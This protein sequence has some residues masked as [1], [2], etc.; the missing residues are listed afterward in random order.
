MSDWYAQY[1]NG[2][3]TRV[4]P[5]WEAELEAARP[6]VSGDLE[7]GLEFSD[8]DP[9]QLH[10]RRRFRVAPI[11]DYQAENWRR[12]RRLGPPEGDQ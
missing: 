10:N 11:T 1:V 12:D 7:H 8:Q 4:L 2:Q 6:G 3:P 9:V 5:R